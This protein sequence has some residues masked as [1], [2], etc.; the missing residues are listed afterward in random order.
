M[1][2]N[3]VIEKTERAFGESDTKTMEAMFPA[4]PTQD[5]DPKE[6]MRSLLTGIQPGNPDL[7]SFSMDFSEAPE[8][9]DFVPNPSNL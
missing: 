4:S 3:T 1:A 7:G 2:T 8:I 9:D 6:L 5:Y